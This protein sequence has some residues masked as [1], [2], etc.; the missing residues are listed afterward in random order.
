MEKR[1]VDGEE[2]GRWRETNLLGGA[3]YTVVC[4]LQ[5]QVTRHDVDGAIVLRHFNTT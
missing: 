2:R 4:V 3:I 1:G 5:P